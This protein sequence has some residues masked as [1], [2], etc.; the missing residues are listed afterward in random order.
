MKKNKIITL[1][2]LVFNFIKSIIDSVR[3]LI[4]SLIWK[5]RILKENIF[6]DVI[7]FIFQTWPKMFWKKPTTIKIWRSIATLIN[8]IFYKEE[9]FKEVKKVDK[10]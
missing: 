4:N 6:L 3:I 8:Y 5:K 1:I 10:K 2:D 9:F 7:N